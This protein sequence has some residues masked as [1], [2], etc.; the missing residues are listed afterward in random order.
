[1]HKA[2]AAVVV[3][4]LFGVS[5]VAHAGAPAAFTIDSFDLVLEPG[6]AFT[7]TGSGCPATGAYPTD[8]PVQLRLT[9]PTGGNGWGPA[10]IGDVLGM[11]SS[12]A[13]IAGEVDVRVAPADDGTFTATMAVPT[14]APAGEG[15]IVRGYCLTVVEP[16][17]EPG[18]FDAET[19][20][21]GY[22]EAGSL[23]V[24]SVVPETTPMSVVGSDDT[25]PRFTG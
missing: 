11:V 7:V 25:R 6:A 4:V 8:S 17:E 20:A 22:A 12:S 15:Y 2:F 21:A 16:G 14:D 24:I 23:D 3:A 19:V 18:S 13:Y 10:L 1:M 9:P 5:T